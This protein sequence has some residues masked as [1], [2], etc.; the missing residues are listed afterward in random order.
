MVQEYQEVGGVLVSP[1]KKPKR[2]EESEGTSCLAS[3]D[4][5]PERG[6]PDDQP[7][8]Y[9]MEKHIVLRS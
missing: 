4:Y 5:I 3:H 6:C 2:V 7:A 1:D 8:P 9:W